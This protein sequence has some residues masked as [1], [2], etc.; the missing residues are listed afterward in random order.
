MC[1]PIVSDPLLSVFANSTLPGP[2]RKVEAAA[3]DECISDVRSDIDTKPM[4]END[5]F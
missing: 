5:V 3:S 1:L 2:L 4:A